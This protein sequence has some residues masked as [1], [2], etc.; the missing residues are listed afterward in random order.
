MANLR[1]LGFGCIAFISPASECVRMAE[2]RLAQL[3]LPF[4]FTGGW[5]NALKI[6]LDI[7]FGFG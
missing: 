3:S 2:L 7:T 4:T 1:W 6:K 5:Q